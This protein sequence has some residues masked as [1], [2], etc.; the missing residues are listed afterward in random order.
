MFL[1]MHGETMR[2]KKRKA[3]EIVAFLWD[4]N[5][6]S[7]RHIETGATITPE[8]TSLAMQGHLYAVHFK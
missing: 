6:R 5:Y 7:I 8:D 1:E 3:F 4:L 2:E